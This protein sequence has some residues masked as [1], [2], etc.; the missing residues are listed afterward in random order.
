MSVREENYGVYYSKFWSDWFVPFYSAWNIN[1]VN[2]Q[3]WAA[4]ILYFRILVLTM[5]MIEVSNIT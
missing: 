3:K 5:L 2:L 1:F 4:I